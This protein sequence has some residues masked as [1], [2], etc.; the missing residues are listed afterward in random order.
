M[1]IGANKKN[2]TVFSKK[3]AYYDEGKGDPIV[4][5]HGNPSSSY[6]WRNIAPNF[7]QSNRVIVPDLI[8]MGDSEKLDG[9]DNENYNFN[10]HYKFLSEFLLSLSIEKNIHLVIHDWGCGLGLK[11]ARLNSNTIKSITFMEGITIP[12]TWEEWPDSGT[13]IFKLFRSE[14]G[15]ELILNK[16][17][18]VERI[19]LNDPFEPMSEET[20]AEYMRPF[21]E[22]GE[23]RRPTLTF[24]RNIPLDK[25][26]VDTY[27]EIKLNEEFHSSSKIPKL[28]INA[29]PGFLLVG[30]QRDKVRRWNNLTEVTVK[31]NHF[32]QEDSPEEITFH[33]KEFINTLK[34]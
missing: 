8:G 25:E 10:G 27:K 4:F 31:G 33:I 19:L 14:A 32:I 13:K 7:F 3:I 6:L 26:P 34:V 16:N 28:F 29:D 1:F 11:Y 20:K 15:E 23:D 17:F 2:I 22:K 21:I 24:P 9:I 30:T 5:L 18:F 12:L